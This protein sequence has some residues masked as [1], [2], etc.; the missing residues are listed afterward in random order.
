MSP[1]NN[2]VNNQNRVKDIISTTQNTFEKLKRE[3]SDKN[4][5][6]EEKNREILQLKIN[7]EELMK[8]NENHQHRSVV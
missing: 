8:R 2:T 3:L 1:H 4:Q 6:I 5:T 7:Q